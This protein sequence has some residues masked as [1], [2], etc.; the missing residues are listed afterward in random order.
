[1][2]HTTP[3]PALP[4]SHSPTGSLDC[5]RLHHHPPN[6]VN[7]SLP[8][9]SG[10]YPGTQDP[11]FLWEL[12]K[13]QGQSSY[14]G[15]LWS[16]KRSLGWT[17]R[18]GITL[19]RY[20][21][22]L[23]YLLCVELS[24]QWTHWTDLLVS[25]RRLRLSCCTSSPRWR[26]KLRCCR[27]PPPLQNFE[28]RVQCA[29]HTPAPGNSWL[30][31]WFFGVFVFVKVCWRAFPGGGGGGAGPWTSTLDWPPATSSTSESLHSVYWLVLCWV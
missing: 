8:P 25:D 22:G 4:S 30:H 14:K 2:F 16:I 20:D 26:G 28:F 19:R 24:E 11:H 3:S 17:T 10:W 13:W 27:G 31:L 21:W 18:T 9:P 1:M 7:S 12:F 23:P 29:A 6:P 15:L 5:S